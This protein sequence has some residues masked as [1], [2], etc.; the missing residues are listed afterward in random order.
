[1]LRLHNALANGIEERVREEQDADLAEATDRYDL[2]F[3]MRKQDRLS[4]GSYW[5]N[6]NNR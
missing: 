6:G 4:G 3:R 5:S 2:E 1:M